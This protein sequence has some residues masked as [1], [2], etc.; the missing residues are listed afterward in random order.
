MGFTVMENFMDSLRVVST[1]GKG[2]KVVLTK[3]LSALP[4]V[5]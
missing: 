4:W 1:V 5:R 2:T 3:K